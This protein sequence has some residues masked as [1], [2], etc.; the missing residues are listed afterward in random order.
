LIQPGS[1][2]A[3]ATGPA[4]P[5]SGVDLLQPGAVEDAGLPERHPSWLAPPGAAAVQARDMGAAPW[6]ADPIGD[7]LVV[8]GLVTG[9]MA[10]VSYHQARSNLDEAARAQTLAEHDRLA[11][12][13]YST[14]TLSVILTATTAG[15]LTT[16][17]LRTSAG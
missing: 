3:Y 11:D 4:P 10:G 5:L 13:A 14:R 1:V 2:P 9:A 6:W 17:S 12:A 7:A 8:G 16:G 15:L